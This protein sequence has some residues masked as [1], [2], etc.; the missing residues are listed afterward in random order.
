[1]FNFWKKSRKNAASRSGPVLGGVALGPRPW[2]VLGGGG[3]KGLTHLGVWRAL[4]KHGFEPAGILGTSIGA[5]VGAC[6][7]AE[8]EVEDLILLANELERTDIARIQG[9]A[10]WISGFRAQA[11]FREQPLRDYLDELLPPAGW[12]ALAVRFQANAVEI[13]RGRTEW[14][15]VGARTD[16]TLAQAI[17]ASAALPVFYPPARLPGGVYVD[18]GVEFALP[19]HRAAE[20]GAT[21][22]VAVDPG[23]GEEADADKVVTGG[24]LAMHQRVFSIMSGRHRRDA[25]AHWDGVPLLYIR[26]RLDGYGTFD[27]EHVPYF[28]EEGERA[29]REAL[30]DVEP[31]L[32]RAAGGAGSGRREVRADRLVRV[33]SSRGGPSAHL[34]SEEGPGA[35]EPPTGTQSSS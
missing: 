34:E 6:L 20:L 24:M 4:R 25:L 13:K 8:R 16:V 12:D 5:L 17:Y 2:L 31:A 14:F 1:V 23:A 32:A 28:L 3:L 18:G 7:A 30:G 10:L 35:S 22:I 9:R 15:G 26:P 11:L 29:G 27:F 33:E 19:I 21:G